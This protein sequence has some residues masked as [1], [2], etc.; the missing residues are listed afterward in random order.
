VV[1]LSLQLWN[2]LVIADTNIAWF[3]IIRKGNTPIVGGAF[4]FVLN[5]LKEP[6]CYTD[7]AKVMEW[8]GN[9]LE[10]FTI[11]ISMYAFYLLTLVLYLVKSRFIHVGRDLQT[12]FG[13]QLMLLLANQ[14]IDAIDWDLEEKEH[15]CCETQHKYVDKEVTITLYHKKIDIKLSEFY[16]NM[17]RP[18]LLRDDK[19]IEPHAALKFVTD[20]VVGD[21]SKRCLDRFRV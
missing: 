11:E 12:T 10:W 20:T 7:P 2:I 15:K 5:K 1:G 19:P 8:S 17:I 3:D 16:Y 21:I 4:F 6:S 9:C 14:I 18:R 13:G